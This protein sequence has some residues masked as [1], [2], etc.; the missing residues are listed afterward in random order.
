MEKMKIKVSIEKMRLKKVTF[1]F[2]FN[3]A[4]IL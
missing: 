4:T 1:K 3:L 2:I